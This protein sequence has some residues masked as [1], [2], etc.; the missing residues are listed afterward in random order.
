MTSGNQARVNGASSELAGN[1]VPSPFLDDN[2]SEPLMV[3]SSPVNPQAAI[4]EVAEAL[5]IPEPASEGNA[6]D[7]EEISDV[8]GRASSKSRA[9]LSVK[10]ALHVLWRAGTSYVTE[11]VQM[12]ANA[13]RDRRSSS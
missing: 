1:S 8:S 6:V 9:L 13:S 10:P 2:T 5:K 12:L 11:A 3:D 4:K 7:E